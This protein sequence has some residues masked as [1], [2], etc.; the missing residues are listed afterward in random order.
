[1]TVIAEHVCMWA[2]ALCVHTGV[3]DACVCVQIPV[4]PYVQ[5]TYIGPTVHNHNLFLCFK[6]IYFLIWPPTPAPSLPPV[7]KGRSHPSRTPTTAPLRLLRAGI[8]SSIWLLFRR[9]RRRI[10]QRRCF[11]SLA[12]ARIDRHSALIRCTGDIFWWSDMRTTKI[13]FSELTGPVDAY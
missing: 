11:W 7:C 6:S 9:G 4:R 5:C 8:V 12:A 2:Y 10:I 1:M 13:P 3:Y